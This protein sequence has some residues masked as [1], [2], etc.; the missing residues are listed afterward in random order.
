MTELS[1]TTPRLKDIASAVGVHPSTASRALNPATAH[2]LS[3]DVVS[4]VKE[5][6]RLMDYSINTL[7]AGLRTRRTHTIGIVVRDLT[8]TML[9]VMFRGI[10]DR[11]RQDNY[12]A[13]LANT[14]ADRQRKADVINAFLDRRVDGLIMTYAEINDEAVAFARSRGVPL[15]F[16]NRGTGDETECRVNPDIPDAMK[17]MVAH[18]AGLGH[19]RIAHLAGPVDST[20]ADEKMNALKAAMIDHGLPIDP[21]LF[22]RVDQVSEPDARRAARKLVPRCKDATAIVAANDIL[23][24]SCIDE[25]EAAGYACPD[26]LSI[27]GFND[28]PFI[29]RIKPGLTTVRIP[30]QEMGFKAADLLL[31]QLDA[32]GT[33]PPGY[34]LPTTLV[35]R[36]STAKSCNGDG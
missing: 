21:D 12:V 3:P 23:A 25:A 2:L 26:R 15:V 31:A 36:G 19:R 20:I 18:L 5:A 32:P 33:S 14:Y 28:M 1:R 6:A 7:A 16:L 13:I 8:N 11:L 9:P 24:L 4:R 34:V 30:H 29:S 10:E 22:M 27:T 35:V 17:Q